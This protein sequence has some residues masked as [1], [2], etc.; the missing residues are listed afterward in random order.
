MEAPRIST[1]LIESSVKVTG[2][3]GQRDCTLFTSS[4]IRKSLARK[5]WRNHKRYIHAGTLNSML[6]DGFLYHLTYPLHNKKCD[7]RMSPYPSFWMDDSEIHLIHVWVKLDIGYWS[8]LHKT[9]WVNV[10]LVSK[11]LS[12]LKI[13]PCW[14]LPFW[15]RPYVFK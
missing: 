6:S 10:S 14:K 1:W 5:L 13:G 15:S 4:H 12:N 2:L 7:R 3:T 11:C 9:T 8:H